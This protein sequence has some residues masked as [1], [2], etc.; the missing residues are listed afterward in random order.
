MKDIVPQSFGL[1]LSTGA[2]WV[3]P[4]FEDRARCSYHRGMLMRL[5]SGR[6]QVVP[7]AR[8]D[9]RPQVAMITE[10]TYPFAGGG[11]AVWCDQL[12]RNL[13]GIDFH[14]LALVLTDG[15]RSTWDFPDN[16]VDVR[17]VPVWDRVRDRFAGTS[18]SAPPAA[19]A[20]MVRLLVEP[21][22]PAGAGG[23]LELHT[24]G[25]VLDEVLQLAV[26][27]TLVDHLRFRCLLD[28]V[29]DELRTSEYLASRYHVSL[30]D[31]IELS[32]ALSHLLAVLAVDPGPVDLVHAT[33]NGLPALVAMGA[34]ARSG[35]PFVMSEHGLY[36]RERY[37]AAP[38]ELPR[39]VVRDVILRFYRL[40]TATA[41]RRATLLAPA[42]D[43]N[44]R[45]QLALGAP[46]ELSWTL[47]NGVDPSAFP[48]RPAEVT[49]PDV[50][51][52]GR[53]DPIKDL[54]TLLRAVDLVRRRI[55]AVR[56]RFF[57]EEPADIRGY[58]QSCRSL[59]E[60]LDLGGNVVFEGR[61]DHPAQA[62]HSG[63]FSVL[64]SISEG[65]PYSVLESMSCGVPV[66]GTSVGGVR[67]AIADT[68]YVVPARDPRLLAEACLL[69]LANPNHRRSMG[70]A[71]RRRVEDLFALDQMVHDHERLYRAFAGRRTAG[72]VAM[73][74]LAD[75]IDL[76]QRIDLTE[77][78][79][80]GAA[81][82]VRR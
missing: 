49:K 4:P 74:D 32:T 29:L 19:I 13:P 25:D 47:H 43:F 33:A 36:L 28:L 31:A 17:Q 69:M 8:D 26:D 5:G 38:T 44:R 12:V 62:F 50:V 77:D 57:G 72:R 67:E 2:H 23:P 7:R 22:D 80:A 52:L 18:R 58:L 56:F 10:G 1:S 40:V 41:L 24:F 81:S 78:R 75:P 61:V 30:A 82:G 46:P 45:W 15:R 37:L 48:A 63:M 55:P 34:R 11:V 53:I 9:D 51:W 14:V 3:E 70:L 20:R 65:F 76:T 35:I 66:V 71:A 39:P 42:S 64:S 6:S 68:G 54:H 60:E 16:V 21:T 59:V 73:I 79:D 27:G